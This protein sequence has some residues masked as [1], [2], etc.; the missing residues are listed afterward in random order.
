MMRGREIA[1]PHSECPGKN[2]S[3]ALRPRVFRL[4]VGRRTTAIP[5]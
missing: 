5:I 2:G 1:R 3:F 4:R